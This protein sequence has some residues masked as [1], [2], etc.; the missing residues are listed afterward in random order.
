MGLGQPS[1]RRCSTHLGHAGSDRA[2]PVVVVPDR[3]DFGAGYY[4]HESIDTRSG[5]STNTRTGTRTVTRTCSRTEHASI[6]CPDAWNSIPNGSYRDHQCASAGCGIVDLVGAA[7]AP[8]W[9]ASGDCRPCCF[10]DSFEPCACGEQGSYTS[11]AGTR[12]RSSACDFT[13]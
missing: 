4:A 8:R 6:R 11:T 10:V 3:Y 7:R 1:R 12:T 2:E 9:W 5:S 13:S